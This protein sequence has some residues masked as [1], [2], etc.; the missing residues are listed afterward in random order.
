MKR[1]QSLPGVF[2]VVSK[3]VAD[4]S[5]NEIHAQKG[6]SRKIIIVSMFDRSTTLR[7]IKSA[8]TPA[9]TQALA[10]FGFLKFERTEKRTFLFA[11]VLYAIVILPVLIADRYNVDDWGRTVLGYSNWDRDGR[12]LAEVVMDILA[13]GK[14]IVDFSPLCQIASIICLSYLSVLASRK[15]GLYGP[16][17]AACATLPLGANPF[18]LANLS[19]KFDSLPM[20]LSM[21]FALL[22]TLQRDEASK[23]RVLPLLIGSGSL[24]GALCLYQPSL[25][26]FLIFAI[27]EC[28]FS[29][30]R[31]ALPR[32]LRALIWSRAGQLFIAGCF[33]KAI[34]FFTV[35]DGYG[36][37][38]S[39]F[40]TDAGSFWVIWRNFIDSWFVVVGSL[41]KLKLALLLPVAV[42]LAISVVVGFRYHRTFASGGRFR[43]LW[44]AIPFMTPIALVLA[45]FGPMIFLASSPTQSMRTFLGFGPLLSCSLILITLTLSELGVPE[46][47]Q[48]VLLSIPAYAMIFFAAIYGNLTK[49]Q[50]EY[51]GDIARRLSDDLKEIVAKQSVDH[52]ILNGTVGFA[53]S[54]ER[55]IKT[56][57]HL[58]YFWVQID[59]HGDESGFGNTVLRYYGARLERETSERKRAYALAVASEQKPAK[60]N[61]HYQVYVVDNDVLVRLFPGLQ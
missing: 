53:P 55:V 10:A 31:N 51:E 59:L 16:F 12:P 28:I 61:I 44:G 52:L 34:L 11:L 41:W 7:G 45:T 4:R 6:K 56:K 15:F 58:L 33:Y 23:H 39:R 40:I 5:V 19:F 46:T 9:R 47:W 3:G 1:L 22:P 26:A 30:M 48:T 27:F 43:L 29:Q 17:T 14:P 57:Y 42:A 21:L 35:R 8:L 37:E 32:E 49:A 36:A 25:N 54:V 20:A 60:A 38:N 13:L 50:K 2:V 18:F 24:L